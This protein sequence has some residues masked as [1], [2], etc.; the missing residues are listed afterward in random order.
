MAEISI[1]IVQNKTYPTNYSTWGLYLWH[2]KMCN[3]M[4]L[5]TTGAWVNEY[6]L[7]CLVLRE[8]FF[9]YIQ[10]FQEKK[11]KFDHIDS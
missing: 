9:N 5:G 6:L 10:K 8:L 11:W 1:Y 4:A 2:M 7:L 3:K